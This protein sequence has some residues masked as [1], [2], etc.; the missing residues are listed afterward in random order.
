[1]SVISIICKFC[2]PD[3]PLLL[4]ILSEEMS[5]EP[6]DILHLSNSWF[7]IETLDLFLTIDD[8]EF[9]LLVMILK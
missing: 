4:D 2:N 5:L 9:D 1:M 7:N 8:N 3:D 6:S